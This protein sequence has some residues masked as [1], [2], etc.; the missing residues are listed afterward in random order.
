MQLEQS[1]LKELRSVRYLV[2]II[3]GLTLINER[4]GTVIHWTEVHTTA[5]GVS[6]L[7][8]L[9][10]D[11]LYLVPVWQLERRREWA[12]KILLGLAYFGSFGFGMMIMGISWDVFTAVIQG[13][14]LHKIDY[15][16]KIDGYVF[17]II[18]G[19]LSMSLRSF[20]T[21]AS[22]RDACQI[23]HSRTSASGISQ[24]AR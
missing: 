20:L 23:R 17:G 1:F 12:R 5:G 9:G 18:Y 3:V 14:M 11:L 15:V 8:L 4:I 13:N 21:K 10:F 24:N 7:V 19:L 22:V 2:S 16:Y 6:L